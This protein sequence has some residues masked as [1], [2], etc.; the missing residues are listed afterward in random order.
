M[1]FQKDNQFCERVL[2]LYSGVKTWFLWES[3][4]ELITELDCNIK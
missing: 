1:I 2:K 3:I 4:I